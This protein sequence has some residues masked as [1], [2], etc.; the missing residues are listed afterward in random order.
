MV[1]EKTVYFIQHLQGDGDDEKYQQNERRFRE[2]GFIRCRSEHDAAG[3]YWEIWLGYPFLLN[4]ELKN[5]PLDVI[6][7]WLTGHGPGEIS[8]AVEKEH[9]GFNPD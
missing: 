2:A 4:G 9:L 7:H 1:K 5:A 6:L 3:K 8:V